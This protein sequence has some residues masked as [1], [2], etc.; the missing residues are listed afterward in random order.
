[1]KFKDFKISTKLTIS[2]III[3]IMFVIASVYQ[4][5]NLNKLGKLQTFVV[6]SGSDY[7]VITEFSLMMDKASVVEASAVINRNI[8][9]SREEWKELMEEF[10][11]D[12]NKVKMLADHEEEK[13][14]YNQAE[15]IV[16]DL[17]ADFDLLFSLLEKDSMDEK[18][19]IALDKKF[20]GYND[21]FDAMGQQFLKFI[22]DELTNADDEFDKSSKASVN[23]SIII[24]IV[25]VVFSILLIILLVNLIAKPLLKGVL[26]AT[27]VANGDL[28]A[29]VDIEQK[30][31]VGQLADA[32][33]GMISRLRDIMAEIQ[34][35]AENITTTSNV[36]S[37]ASEQ[38]SSG[39]SQMSS[40]TQQ[41][42]QGASE[43]SSSTEQISSSMEEMVA[44][45]QQN[46]SNAQETEKISLKASTD[47]DNVY[48][49]SRESIENITH[50]ADKISIIT[51]IAFQTNILALNAAV[52]A[53]RAGE[54]GK[55]FAVVAAEVRKLAERS[56]IAADEINELSRT[57][58]T[59]T[60]EAGE[61]LEKI[62]PDIQNTTKLVQEIA[63]ACMEQ[64]SGADQIN[65]AI[66]QL[67]LVTQQNAAA[68][69][70][71]ATS[72]EELASTSEELSNNA[73]ELSNQSEILKTAISFFKTGD[74]AEIRRTVTPREQLIKK[75]GVV[76]TYKNEKA[77]TN[78][79]AIK[80][81]IGKG[82]KVDLA[83]ESSNDDDFVTF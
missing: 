26:F 3:I 8:D 54:H 51:D 29:T 21:Q 37:T 52:E 46:N 73:E 75:Q 56:K 16:K 49:K 24:M 65:N 71:M 43:Q 77:K 45:I 36:L 78:K 23:I 79:P 74:E 20:D 14:L 35:G 6:D 18:T 9:K 33:K 76:K 19:I 57:S 53:A 1:M 42:S 44:N 27:K 64:N 60:K 40:S 50:I 70:E 59:A 72:A 11:M 68:A 25:V 61:L 4:I 31:E 10:K 15:D 58:V 30:D 17:P 63:A 13:E 5:L 83:E 62:I 48:K 82:T 38:L 32:L 12:M 41:V 7:A 2:F 22:Q 47:V 66:Q 67:N 80:K 39:A 81:E 28:T 55:G 34:S 69:E